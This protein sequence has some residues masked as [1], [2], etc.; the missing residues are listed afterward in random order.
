VTDVF[1][2]TS[3]ILNLHLFSAIIKLDLPSPHLLQSQFYVTVIRQLSCLL[4]FCEESKVIRHIKYSEEK[5]II[6]SSVEDL[7]TSNT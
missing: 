3:T 1:V 7:T 4:K 5:N 2:L 6:L